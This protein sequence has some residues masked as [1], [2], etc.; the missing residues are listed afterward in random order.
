MD[1][2]KEVDTT[3]D[4]KA[5]FLSLLE[6][7]EAMD[8]TQ[9]SVVPHTR[10]QRTSNRISRSREGST[11][12]DDVQEVEGEAE[13]N[14]DVVMETPKG[15]ETDQMDS[16]IDP[17]LL[18]ARIQH[19]PELPIDE[20]ASRGRSSK[21]P[22]RQAPQAKHP[23]TLKLRYGRSLADIDPSLTNTASPSPKKRRRT[24]ILAELGLDEASVAATQDD[25]EMDEDAEGSV[26]EDDADAEQAPEEEPDSFVNRT[27]MSDADGEY[28]EEEDDIARRVSSRPQRQSG[29]SL[30]NQDQSYSDFFPDVNASSP[31]NG[32]P[33][34]LS[35]RSR[36]HPPILYKPDGVRIQPSSKSSSRRAQKLPLR[37][38][39]DEAS[40]DRSMSIRNDRPVSLELEEPRQPEDPFGGFLTGQAASLGDRVPEAAD[41]QLYEQVISASEQT[42][43]QN[44][45][46][47]PPVTANG[48]GPLGHR[49]PKRED[50]NGFRSASPINAMTRGLK[51]SLT[52]AEPPSRLRMHDN[53][54]PMPA[55]SHGSPAPLTNGSF[56]PS[57]SESVAALT[58][59]EG[60]YS[61]IAAIRFGQEWEIKTWYQAPYPEEYARVPDGRLWLCEF[62]LQYF[63]TG[64][65]AGRHRVSVLTG[66]QLHHHL[67]D[68]TVSYCS[69]Q[70]PE[71][72]S[73]RR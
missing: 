73:A 59:P 47:H 58:L 22:D 3:K 4:V 37:P 27:D 72:A 33:T 68:T 50:L 70:V 56:V 43:L 55:A 64:F 67:S 48:D 19:S 21:L 40:F 61:N 51:D 57:R 71:S 62:C 23:H 38:A 26:E 60:A 25:V 32:V 45:E 14:D 65:T 15:S 35:G 52:T 66:S 42:L 69:A 11:R 5:G 53:N 34:T 7:A 54:M 30:R 29:R 31:R 46:Y 63:R 39:N 12:R 8:S 2:Q 36:R 18:P 13:A 24:G 9:L 6:A 44:L 17:Q 20:S 41:R 10:A 28:V 16:L 49:R 1:M